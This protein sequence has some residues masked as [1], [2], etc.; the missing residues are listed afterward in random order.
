M[1]MEF[2]EFKKMIQGL[3]E[4]L[5]GREIK[6]TSTTKNNGVILDGLCIYVPGREVATV[7][8]LESYY[9]QYIQN[10]ISVLDVVEQIFMI[11]QDKQSDDICA[12]Q[13]N[14]FLNVQ[15]KI[16]F[17]IINHEKNNKLLHTIPYEEVLDLVIV[18]YILVG[19]NDQGRRVIQI[20]NAL[21][22]VWNVTIADLKA[23]AL[24][25]CIRELPAK[26][27]TVQEEIIG[28]DYSNTNDHLEDLP[29]PP[30]YYLSNS[31]KLNGAGCM[32]YPDLLKKFSD[33]IGKDLIIIPSS[34]HETLIIPDDEQVTYGSIRSL[35]RDVNEH[36]VSVEE[37][38][39]DNIYGYNRQED[40]LIIIP[41][42][43]DFAAQ[44][45]KEE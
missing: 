29:C 36:V 18:F 14:N 6:I 20:T 25:N 10:K 27:S 13:I 33:L 15:N 7:V 45:V 28:L 41:D 44:D 42:E 30:M 34:I 2:L 1:N 37:K 23:V 11:A 38:L 12:D 31:E 16:M 8:Y 35:V 26:I 9:R 4:E 17:K 22:D 21:M 40:Q 32:L 5:L 19:E 3:L 43:F 39:S 24:K